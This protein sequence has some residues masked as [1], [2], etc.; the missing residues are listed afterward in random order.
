MAA[1]NEFQVLAS[2]D[3]GY[4]WHF[5]SANGEVVCASQVYATKQ[6]AIH[7]AYVLKLNAA[8]APV[9]DYTGEA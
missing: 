8:D 1:Q 6:G 7:G 5:K 9:L 4:Y 2:K 3:G